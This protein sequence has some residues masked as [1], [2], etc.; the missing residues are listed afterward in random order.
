VLAATRLPRP[1]SFGLGTPFARPARAA[2]TVVAVLLGATTVVFAVGL[3]TSL[4]R[5]EA[6][7]TRA[8]AVPVTVDLMGRGGPGGIGPGPVPGP[9]IGPEPETA[10]PATVRATIQAQPGTARLVGI[11][12]VEVGLA[13]FTEPLEVSAYDSDATWVGYPLVSGRWYEGADEAVAGSRMLRLTGTKVGDFIT[14]STELGQRRVHIVGEAF[15]NSGDVVVM[16]DASGLAGLAGLAGH[17]G[18]AGHVAPNRFEVA[19]TGGTDPHAYVT[20]L[21]ATFGGFAVVPQVTADQEDNQT[22]IIMRSLIITLSVL[23][24]SVAALGVFNTVV[25]DT[26]ERAY[27]IGVLASI[28]MTPRQVLVMVVTSM[29]TVGVLGGALAVPLGWA[30]HRWVLRAIA[31]SVGLGIP[32]SLMA[33]YD[34]VELIALGASGVALAVL[35]SLVPAGW[36]ART[37]AAAALRAE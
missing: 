17:S 19:L 1:V 32:H 26:R 6:A 25:L 23:L 18:H 20:A 13:G 21:S 4:T 22:I 10:D 16:M 24:A 33:V 2:V 27:E 36:A 28:G 31:D 12:Q 5:A 15:S 7:F 37:R 14:I 8:S 35:G 3:T 9:A 11:S 34:P 30:V 29:V